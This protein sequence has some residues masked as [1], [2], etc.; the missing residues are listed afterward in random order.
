MCS[1]LESLK[2]D[3]RRDGTPDAAIVINLSG[4]PLPVPSSRSLSAFLLLQLSPPLRQ[5][6]LSP[7]LGVLQ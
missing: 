1:A 3:R 7:L 4:T 6:T 5:T 2:L